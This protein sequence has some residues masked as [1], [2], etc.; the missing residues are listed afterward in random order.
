VDL[1]VHD[2]TLVLLSSDGWL[3]LSGSS[4]RGW[5]GDRTPGSPSWIDQPVSVTIE[6][7]RIHLLEARRSAVSVWDTLGSRIREIPIP[8]Q[9]SLASHPKQLLSGPN[10]NLLVVLLRI[11]VDG[12]ASWDVLGMDSLG[13]SRTVASFPNTEETM[14]FQEPRLARGSSYLLMID[15]LRYEIYSLETLSGRTTRTGGRKSPPLW[16]VP[17]SR[18][19]E[20]QDLLARMD[21]TL[22]G[23]SALPE[24]WPSI[25]DLTVCRDGSLLISVTATE[26]RVHIEHLSPEGM[27]LGRFNV[28][29]FRGP[30]FLSD[31]R[32]FLADQDLEETVI[33]EYIF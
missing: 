21:R 13:V 27:P 18:K 7:G 15:P 11:E 14:L 23:L 22:A 33:Y 3:L 8:R 20:Y 5:F 6:A 4:L 10:G 2:S 31:G 28:E 26:D 19:R 12:A 30:V 25:R 32:A 1:A 29:G 17:R 16:N 24:A 9:G